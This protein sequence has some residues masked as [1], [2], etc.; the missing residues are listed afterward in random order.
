MNILSKK[1]IKRVGK[2]NLLY[3]AKHAKATLSLVGQNLIL[4]KFVYIEFFMLVIVAL[5]GGFLVI[6]FLFFEA[7]DPVQTAE[8]QQQRLTASTIDELELWIEERH[9]AYQNPPV[10]PPQVFARPTTAP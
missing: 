5:V 7:A 9:T 2:S 1:K 10:I 6:S 8:P 4:R 3:Q